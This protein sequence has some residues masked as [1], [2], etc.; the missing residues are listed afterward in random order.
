MRKTLG[1]LNRQLAFVFFRNIIMCS[2]STRLRRS[3]AAINFHVEFEWPYM[4][5][6]KRKSLWNNTL[7]AYNKDFTS[8]R[9]W[10]KGWTGVACVQDYSFNWDNT[11]LNMFQASDIWQLLA[12]AQVSFPASVFYQ[13]PPCHLSA[14]YQGHNCYAIE[15]WN[16]NRAASKCKIYQCLKTNQRSARLILKSTF[17]KSFFKLVNLQSSA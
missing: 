15:K 1:V 16:A 7:E 5:L 8:R 13:S 3:S 2:I 14:V 4:Y 6:A 11:L 10:Q 17:N 9:P 12:I